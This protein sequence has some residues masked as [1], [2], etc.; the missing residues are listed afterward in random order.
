MKTTI[1]NFCMSVWQ[2]VQKFDGT[3]T[4]SD[5]VQNLNLMW[6]SVTPK[7]I[8]FPISKQLIISYEN[9][10]T[11]KFNPGKNSL[12]SKLRPNSYLWWQNYNML[13]SIIGGTVDSL[14][15]I[16]N[17]KVFT[18]SAFTVFHFWIR[19]SGRAPSELLISL[20]WHFDCQFL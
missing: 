8:P 17:T 19:C 1:E 14:G 13:F 15:N 11:K 2:F 4:D 5:G 3:L 12:Q 9:K 16:M 20:Y 18:P 10:T 6:N 7:L